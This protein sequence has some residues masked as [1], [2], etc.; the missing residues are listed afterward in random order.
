M[1]S[2]TRE[3]RPQN[4][5]VFGREFQRFLERHP[6]IPKIRMHDMRHSAATM[7]LANGEHPKVVSERLADAIFGSHT[8]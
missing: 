6:E 1:R 2:G 7:M 3:G 8:R 4:P 5:D